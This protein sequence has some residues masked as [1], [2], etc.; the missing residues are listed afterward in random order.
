MKKNSNHHLPPDIFQ[1]VVTHTPLVSIDLVVHDRA[2]RVLVGLRSNRPARGSWFVPGGRIGKNETLA[3]AFGRI[4]SSELGERVEITQARF[5]GVFEH[6]YPDCFAGE[7]T[8]THY[9]VLAWDLQVKGL[10]TLPEEQHDA[11]RWLSPEDLVTD[12]DVHEN[13]KVYGREMGVGRI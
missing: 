11:Y 9:V 2:G 10:E 12:A 8:S 5:R 13:T 4:T 7:Q 1:A 3:E 6:F